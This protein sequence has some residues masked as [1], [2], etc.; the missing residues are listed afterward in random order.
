MN[1]RLLDLVSRVQASTDIPSLLS[2]VMD[3]TRDVTG[4]QVAGVAVLV[5]QGYQVSQVGAPDYL[6][7]SY[8]QFTVSAADPVH[9]ALTQQHGVIRTDDLFT[10]SAWHGH[11]FYQQVEA[12]SGLDS[13][14][15]AEIVDAKGVRGFVGASRRT[16]QPPFSSADASLLQTACLHISAALTRLGSVIP[17]QSLTPTEREVV[18]LVARGFTNQQIGQARGV[19]AHAVKKTL[20]RLFEKIG[21]TSRTELIAALG[22]STEPS[23][24]GR[25]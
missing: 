15:A 5:N 18:R 4:A 25:A 12:P 2:A 16:G 7:E 24:W 6:L 1:R 14:M 17:L 20:E 3:C 8:T 22:V 19:T 23:R 9:E 13:Y 10:P 21:V 11:P